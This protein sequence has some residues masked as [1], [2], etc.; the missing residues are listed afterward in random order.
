MILE[1]LGQ[2]LWN[3]VRS[4]RALFIIKLKAQIITLRVHEYYK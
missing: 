3:T 2:I 4:G 1:G